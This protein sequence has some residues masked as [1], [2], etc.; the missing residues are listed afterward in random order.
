MSATTDERHFDAPALL[1][2]SD[3]RNTG[4]KWEVDIPN[5]IAVQMENLA[6]LEWYY[7]HVR[8]QAPKCL[9]THRR[10][11][12]TLDFVGID[13]GEHGHAKPP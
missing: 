12:L 13:L 5:R 9:V 10:K 4:I 6:Y 8:P 7:L 1:N 3:D 2:G 11:K